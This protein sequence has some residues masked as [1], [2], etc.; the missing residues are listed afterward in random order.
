MLPS[1]RIKRLS[2]LKIKRVISSEFLIHMRLSFLLNYS[3]RSKKL[4]DAKR[5]NTGQRKFTPRDFIL[6]GILWCTKHNQPYTGQPNGY[7][8][9]YY[10][11]AERKRH[12]KKIAPCPF[13]KKDAIETLVLDKLKT[14]IFTQDRVRRGLEW[15]AKERIKNKQEDDSE[16]N[17]LRSEI[18]ILDGQLQRYYKLIDEGLQMEAVAKPIAEKHE[19]KG[20]LE[21][22]LSVLEAERERAVKIPVVTEEDVNGAMAT[23]DR[24]FNNSDPKV[25]KQGISELIDR[26]EVIGKEIKVY[27]TFE[28]A[29]SLATTKDGLKKAISYWKRPLRDLNPRS[30]P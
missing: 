4:L 1:V 8:T 18:A 20:R 29:Q 6:S 14:E 7:K 17:E 28:Q 24:I 9:D 15:M 11:C 10:A 21:K 13:I 27:Y 5:P 23:V 2:V 12:G 25:L 19:Q 3:T 16:I 26:I 30:P 22:R